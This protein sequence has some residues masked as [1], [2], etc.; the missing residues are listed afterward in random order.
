MES[1]KSSEYEDDDVEEY[2]EDRE[3]IEEY[4]FGNSDPKND[5]GFISRLIFYWG[6]RIIKL[7]SLTR[8]NLSDLGILNR[9]NSSVQ[10]SKKIFEIWERYKNTKNALL[11]TVLRANL[12]NIVL[13]LVGSAISS[14]L[15][16]YL[17]N[18]FNLFITEYTRKIPEQDS[19]AE[20]IKLE[21]LVTISC[22]Y[23]GIKLFMVFFHRKLVEYQN[24]MGYKAGLQ[25]DCL[26]YRKILNSSLTNEAHATI[27]DIVN[28]IQLHIII[29]KILLNRMIYLSR[30]KALRE[31][32]MGKMI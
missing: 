5:S 32:N 10:Y 18:L 29:I 24:E 23:L 3:K 11:K 20:K 8:L 1:E 27:A 7:A 17:V 30:F 16:I 13:V 12:F 31:W 19:S 15:S 28:Y 2:E 21:K 4:S 22:Q 14:G 9:D 6:Y 26:V 25:L